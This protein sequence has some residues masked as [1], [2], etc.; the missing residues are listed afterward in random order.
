[1]E[2]QYQI[3]VI[4]EKLKRVAKKPGVYLLKTKT[5]DILYVGKAKIL[6]DRL[7]SHFM[8][9]KGQDSKHE[10]MM[11]RVADFETII[12]DSEVEA[13]ILEANFVKEHRPRYNVNLKDDKSYPYI[14][15][16][17]EPYPRILV[18]RKIVRD[19]SRYFGPY[20]DVGNMRQLLAAI[21]RIFPMRTCQIRITEES[22]QQKK[23]KVCLNQHIGRCKG[24]CEGLI[25]QEE[26]HWIVNQVVAF[27]Q[28][29]NHQLVQD[30][31][32]RMKQLAAQK[33][34]E[35][36]AAIRN[37]IRSISTFQS[38]QKVVD[39][40]ILDRDLIAVAAEG[41]D[42]CGVVFNVREGKITNRHHFYLKGVESVSQEEIVSS[43]LK[44]YYLQ[45]EY[46]PE[47][48]F[49]SVELPELSDVRD[50][51]AQK[52]GSRVAI[53]S[54]KRGKKAKLMEMCFKNARLLLEE[55]QVQKS[56][57]SDWIA[58]SVQA[59][60][61]DLGLAFP[62]KHIEAFDISNIQGQHAVASMVFFENGKPK[63][64]E[65]RKFKIKT[66]EG[67]DDFAMM[68]EVVRRRYSRL[69]KEEKSLPDLVLVDGGKGQLSAA[70]HVLRKLSIPN[71]PVIGLA[72]RLEEVFVPGVS[73]PQ[74]IPKSSPSL[75][76]L[77]RIRDEAHRFAVTFHRQQR[78]KY[79]L[80]SELDA[81]PGI[82]ER[83]RNAL[84]KAFGSVENIRKASVEE[85]ANVEGMNRKAAERVAV[86]LRND[87]G[88]SL[89]PPL[90]S[91]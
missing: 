76:L 70:V 30:L 53:V 84:L 45:S 13:L 63:K 46:I 91:R 42:G 48:I 38:K 73:D 28:G 5:G 3:T 15:V 72:K 41:D 10:R 61:K 25:S 71:P 59:L 29:K 14:R 27:I 31:T 43:F 81:I 11:A 56:H 67:I 1:M 2:S 66:V 20:T 90:D 86:A 74:N 22:I 54:P 21:R 16:T 88:E 65:Y 82:G 69:L 52:R 49:L 58:P 4:R 79:T 50:W 75:R 18:T 47:E 19:G 6:R 60:K 37:E 85:I 36:A 83:R 44:Q 40:F 12:T 64:S 17:N 34:Y 80:H 7:R 77:Q 33:Q 78:K 24:V 62:P 23:H 8:P 89:S 26:Y 32:Q 35:E 57:S 51:L 87:S 68:A 55:L 9:G 39:A